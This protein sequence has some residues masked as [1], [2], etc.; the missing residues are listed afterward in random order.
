MTEIFITSWDKR[1]N[2]EDELL[3]LA[4]TELK[5]FK[6][7]RLMTWN[8]D[9]VAPLIDGDFIKSLSQEQQDKLHVLIKAL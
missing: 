7:A 3:K 1:Q 6:G 8:S 4:S 5:N 9:E 2:F